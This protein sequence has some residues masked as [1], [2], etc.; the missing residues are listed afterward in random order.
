MLVEQA[1]IAVSAGWA[2]RSLT[3]LAAGTK[4]GSRTGYLRGL[5]PCWLQ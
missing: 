2:E 4:S 5:G 1:L 3:M